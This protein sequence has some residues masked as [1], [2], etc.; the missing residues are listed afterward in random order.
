MYDGLVKINA[1]QNF[2][3]RNL[4]RPVSYQFKTHSW[5]NVVKHYDDLVNQHAWPFNPMLDLVR[6]LASSPYAP[7]LFPRTSH[8]LLRI[9]RVRDFT[10]GDNEL[11]I[12]FDG[13]TQRFCFTYTQRT[14]DLHPWSRECEASQWREVLER[15]FHKRLRW[16]HEG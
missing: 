16:F 15:L 2:T 10:P 14:D 3:C 4:L 8:D 11:Q 5:Q 6:F 7:S 12:K 1:S 13:L 9:G